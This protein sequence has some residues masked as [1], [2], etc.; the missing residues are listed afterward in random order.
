V[1]LLLC[2]LGLQAPP[3]SW[4]PAPAPASTAAADPAGQSYLE[5]VR[6]LAQQDSWPWE[7]LEALRANTPARL[8][9]LASAFAQANAREQKLGA[10]L[11][12]G[13]AGPLAAALFRAGVQTVD[14]GLGVACLLAPAAPGPEW[15]PAL[16]RIALARPL[17]L[18]LRAV[19]TARLIEAGCWGVWPVA[20]SIL[21][22]GTAMDEPAP[23][24]NWQ[25]AGRYELPKRLLLVS[26][27]KRLTEAGLPACGIEPNGPWADQE[28][29]LSRLEPQ[30]QQL[31]RSMAH[32][33]VQRLSTWR[34]LLQDA[35][36]GDP[37]AAQVLAML[38]E[39]A[40]PLLRAALADADPAM[41]WAARQALEERPN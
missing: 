33:A 31:A 8:A 15:W 1:I 34:A 14:E 5:S 32:P 10:I 27:D 3:A 36:S 4:L 13:C 23:W 37:R 25:R 40:L 24:A 9:A 29:A 12:S 11:G 16:T 19:A 18:P 6:A 2:A 35:A 39:S 7:Q 17:S 26:L 22:T 41:S 38:A 20:R 30:I 28:L 21:R